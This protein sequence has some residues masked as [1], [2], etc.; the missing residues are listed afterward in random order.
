M[1]M[2]LGV[3]P[4][5]A[6]L[7]TATNAQ[8]DEFT[9][10]GPWQALIAD[11]LRLERS[12]VMTI[13][14]AAMTSSSLPSLPLHRP[15]SLSNEAVAD[16]D[17]DLESL[18]L[19]EELGRGAFGIVHSG[20]LH[21][22]NVAVKIK[23]IPA[24]I[25]PSAV[26]APTPPVP[27]L[28]T[29]PN[30]AATLLLPTSMSSGAI[31]SSYS[32]MP[33]ALP[34]ASSLTINDQK[35]ADSTPSSSPP[36]SYGGGANTGYNVYTYTSVDEVTKPPSI[37]S[38]KEGVGVKVESLVESAPSVDTLASEVQALRRLNRHGNI[39]RL[40]G[41]KFEDAPT[42]L[43]LTA[44][45]AGGHIHETK[46]RSN[47]KATS[48][49]NGALRLLIVTEL[50]PCTLESHL[51]NDRS[52]QP[53]RATVVWTLAR[54]L[55]AGLYFLHHSGYAHCDITPMNLLLDPRRMEL[56]IA[57][58]GNS[59]VVDLHQSAGRPLM[60]NDYWTSPD[61]LLM[62]AKIATPSSNAGAPRTLRQ[63]LMAHDIYVTGVLLCYLLTAVKPPSGHDVLRLVGDKA[64]PD[65]VRR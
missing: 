5:A 19:G 43:P 53:F 60:L 41:A 42:P 10:R 38:S 46:D 16:F 15:L 9:R 33:D 12:R 65:Q 58:L 20:I 32:P 44:P 7:V 22:M 55:A 3:I 26:I 11:T 51:I 35:R 27:T 45:S 24:P 13:T 37:P 62:Q 50:M 8:L 1:S 36:H 2:Y 63:L 21:G 56:K 34:P 31:S 59:V 4:T 28:P 23:F 39:I 6:E 40:Y 48:Q 52:G 49:G 61:L 14:S 18:V 30:A 54:Q 47:N 57:D 25:A 17:T 29:L 64:T